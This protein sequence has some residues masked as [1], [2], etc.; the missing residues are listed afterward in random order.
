MG[1]T[2]ELSKQLL[3][4]VSLRCQI[5]SRSWKEEPFETNPAETR[6]VR[7]RQVRGRRQ[8]KINQCSEM[9]V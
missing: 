8:T 5:L 3:Y 7:G 9:D 1:K 4:Y 6:Q 2:M